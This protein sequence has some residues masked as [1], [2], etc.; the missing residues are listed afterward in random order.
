MAFELEA[1]DYDI[2]MEYH[3]VGATEGTLV[4]CF[5]PSQTAAVQLL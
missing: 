1:G 2:E 5:S 3:P 4:S